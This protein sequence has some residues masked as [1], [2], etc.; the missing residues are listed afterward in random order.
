[1]APRVD[2]WNQKVSGRLRQTVTDVQRGG[3]PK[4]TSTPCRLTIARRRGSGDAAFG[5]VRIGQRD[6]A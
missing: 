3:G 6:Q 5:A 1:M 4:A 2:A